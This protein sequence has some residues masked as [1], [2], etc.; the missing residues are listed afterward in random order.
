MYGHVLATH[1]KILMR[2]ELSFQDYCSLEKDRNGII[3]GRSFVKLN[4]SVGPRGGR[5][6]R[7]KQSPRATALLFCVTRTTPI[8][9]WDIA[10][11]H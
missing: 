4:D 8:E 3:F 7:S 10:L 9:F 1:F 5:G 6:R 11:H 2:I